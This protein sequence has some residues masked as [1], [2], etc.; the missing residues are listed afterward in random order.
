MSWGV[1]LL[2]SFC[3]TLLIIIIISVYEGMV[4]RRRNPGQY[5]APEHVK[6]GDT[7]VK[8]KP[9]AGREVKPGS[10]NANIQANNS[11]SSQDVPVVRPSET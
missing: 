3:I 7:V 10:Q 6:P 1:Q 4:Y 5:I 9:V 2:L 11:V 8:Q